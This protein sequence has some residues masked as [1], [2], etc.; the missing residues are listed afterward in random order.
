MTEREQSVSV[1]ESENETRTHECSSTKTKAARSD[2]QYAQCAQRTNSLGERE[3]TE[4]RSASKALSKHKSSIE[5]ESELKALEAFLRSQ[6]KTLRE[7]EQERVCDFK[8]ECECRQRAKCHSCVC[9]P[10]KRS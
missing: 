4:Q 7:R 5:V 6:L 2:T 8:R 1:W 10:V 3:A 9:L